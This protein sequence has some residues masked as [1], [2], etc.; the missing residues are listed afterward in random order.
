[1]LLASNKFWE[2]YR[3]CFK[4]GYEN[5]ISRLF[6][7]PIN[8]DWKILEIN[9]KSKTINTYKHEIKTVKINS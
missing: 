9:A 1:M 3:S 8:S 6:L 4:N 2:K 7:E 5:R